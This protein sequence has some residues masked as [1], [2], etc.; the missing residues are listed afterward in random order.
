MFGV[1]TIYW[2]NTD[3][4]LDLPRVMC[5][6]EN[7]K[8]MERPHRDWPV[9]LQGCLKSYSWNPFGFLR[10]KVQHLLCIRSAC[11]HIFQ[12]FLL[13]PSLNKPESAT[14]L[15]GCKK[16]SKSRL[17][18]ANMLKGRGFGSTVCLYFIMVPPLIHFAGNHPSSHCVAVSPV[19]LMDPGSL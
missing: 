14:C 11:D 9:D 12:E 4:L 18:D 5:M 2:R 3:A 16:R 8:T 10:A 19:W 6:D 13:V 15:E 7:T 17:C 1:F